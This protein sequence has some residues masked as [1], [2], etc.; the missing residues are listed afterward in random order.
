VQYHELNHRGFI[1]VIKGKNELTVTE[2]EKIYF[3]SIDSETLM[4]HLENVMF[5]YLS[6]SKLLFGARGFYCISYQEGQRSYT[7][8]R[9]KYDHDLKIQV[10]DL[11]FEG[12]QGIELRKHNLFLVSQKDRIIFYNSKTFKI[13][14]ELQIESIETNEREKN[15]ILVI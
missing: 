9:R 2:S 15:M 3:Y 1:Y 14:K 11:N 6:C 12:S 8:H 4:P 5:N 7:V 10:S 13:E